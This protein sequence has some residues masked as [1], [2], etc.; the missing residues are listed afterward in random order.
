MRLWVSGDRVAAG[1]EAAV[2]TGRATFDP[3]RSNRGEYWLF[4]LLSLSG[5]MLCCN[6]ND[7]IWLFL[8]LELTSLP[9]Y[10]MVAI[11]RG[12]RKA[13]EAAVKYFFLG[14]MAAAMF[15]YGFALLYGATGT[16]VLTE[17]RTA[18]QTQMESGGLSRAPSK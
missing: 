4:F 2:E 13:Q 15:L 11:S 6:A 12:S 7:L 1:Y 18:L 3:I 10:I 16:I 9:T 5:V 8:A 17:M 14:A